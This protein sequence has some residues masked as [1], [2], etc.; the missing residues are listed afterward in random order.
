MPDPKMMSS[1]EWNRW[2]AQQVALKGQPPRTIKSGYTCK[3]CGRCGWHE[4]TCKNPW[5][6]RKSEGL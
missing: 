6:L 5:D 4:M 2:F 3:G 1:A